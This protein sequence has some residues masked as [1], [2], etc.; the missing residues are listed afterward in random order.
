[1]ENVAVVLLD[2]QPQGPFDMVFDL[3]YSPKFPVKRVHDFK[4][5]DQEVTFPHAVFVHPGCASNAPC[6]VEQARRV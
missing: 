6:C 4:K 3:V 5:S 1:M 2:E